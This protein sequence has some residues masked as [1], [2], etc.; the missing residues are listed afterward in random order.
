MFYATNS[1]SCR[2]LTHGVPNKRSFWGP[3][4][5]IC[6]APVVSLTCT[7]DYYSVISPTIFCN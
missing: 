1:I 3:T 7:E 4:D 2:K 5:V 6:G